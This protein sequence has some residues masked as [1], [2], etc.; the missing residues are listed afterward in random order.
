M[1]AMCPDCGVELMHSVA[2][3]VEILS[4]VECGWRKA[5]ALVSTCCEASY[6]VNSGGGVTRY[7]ICDGCGGDCD[8]KVLITVSDPVNEDDSGRRV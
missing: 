3:D 7:Y 4:C 5:T 6:H 8:P 2:S 1:A